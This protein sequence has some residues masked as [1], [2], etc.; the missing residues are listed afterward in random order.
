MPVEGDFRMFVDTGDIIG[1]SL[2]TRRVW[3][4]HVTP[5]VLGLLSEG[6]VF[7]DVG[8]HVGYYALMAS[9]IVGPTGLV[10]ALEPSSANRALLEAN[11]RRSGASNVRLLAIAA[12]AEPGG[13]VLRTPPGADAA[14]MSLSVGD[15]AEGDP[16][17][18]L[19][20]A[21]IVDDGDAVRLS[22]VKID[23]EG[24]E[25]RVLQ[26]LEPLLSRGA[27]PTILLELHAHLNPE[28]GE[29]VADFCRRNGMTPHLIGDDEG[30][31]RRFA[32]PKADV[33]RAVTPDWIVTS[34]VEH[35][36]LLLVPEEAVLHEVL[37][38]SH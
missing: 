22:L 5:L 19:P 30:F 36:E 25:D 7:V 14:R 2:A 21:D 11:V 34:L 12:G 16:V 33:T 29:P 24:Y 10:Y 13:G 8:A 18:I 31:N 26:G 17:A 3:E 35:H 37:T 38:G 6:Q 28:V 4:P 1:S 32:L 15:A 9:K 23:V 27:R 20:L